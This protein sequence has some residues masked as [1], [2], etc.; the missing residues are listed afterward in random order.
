[1]KL[2]LNILVVVLLSVCV[3]ATTLEERRQMLIG[4]ARECKVI[5]GASDADIGLLAAK[6]RPETMEGKCLFS[7]ILERTNIVRLSNYLLSDILC[8]LLIFQIKDGA[9]NRENF[10]AAAAVILSGDE[11]K[12]NAAVELANECM[13]VRAADR[14][15]LA[16]KTGEC[17][18]IGG[19]VKRID[20]GF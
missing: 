4:I 17:V 15:E 6:K 20:F 7:C 19:I 3:N 18:R 16:F 10:L 2:I 8:L 5:E 1:M 14:C 12:M 11:D 9:L 13:H